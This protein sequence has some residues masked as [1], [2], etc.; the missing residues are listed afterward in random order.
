[1]VFVK[2]NVNLRVPDK[3]H[4]GWLWLPLPEC[5]SSGVGGHRP[6]AWVLLSGFIRGPSSITTTFW[7]KGALS[8]RSLANFQALPLL[9]LQKRSVPFP[10]PRHFYFQVPPFPREPSCFWSSPP[11]PSPS[12]HTH[13]APFVEQN[14]HKFWAAP[15]ASLPHKYS[16]CQNRSDFFSPSAAW[17]CIFPIHDALVGQELIREEEFIREGVW[18]CSAHHKSQTFCETRNEPMIDRHLDGS[19]NSRREELSLALMSLRW[20]VI[21][22]QTVAATLVL[23]NSSAHQSGTWSTNPALLNLIS[24]TF[25]VT[26]SKLL[27]Q[28]FSP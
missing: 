8:E 27:E 26:F 3:L 4:S 2:K 28:G 16:A 25:P 15:R 11:V 10:L 18:L 17:C 1:M 20:I 21:Q 24:I 14:I 7:W 5:P 9:S 22:S 12:L 23:G 6:L 19:V 13:L